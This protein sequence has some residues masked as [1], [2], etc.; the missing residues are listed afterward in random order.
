MATVL[1]AQAAL[2][3]KLNRS[4]P[5]QKE[6]KLIRQQQQ[7]VAHD[8]T[9]EDANEHYTEDGGVVQST[10]VTPLADALDWLALTDSSNYRT[11]P[12]VFTPD[13]A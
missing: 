2:N 11:V 8:H 13:S 1:P 7:Q 9:H 5:T 12:V 4:R 3:A 10:A 6:R